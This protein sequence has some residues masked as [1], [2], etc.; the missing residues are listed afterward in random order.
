MARYML[1]WDYDASRCPLDMKEK[2]S[3]WL[4]LT[5]IVKKQLKNGE[6]KE[7]AHFAGETAGYVIVEGN[8]SDALKITDTY[9]PYVKF[10]SK[11]L[12]TIEQCEQV[13]K[14]L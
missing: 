4:A 6:I 3:Q 1:F 10:T 11:V 14:S 2:T 13:W 12:L 7:W 9:V 5:D 8:E